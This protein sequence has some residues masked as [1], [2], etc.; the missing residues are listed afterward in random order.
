MTMTKKFPGF[1]KQMPAF[2]RGL[3]K[4]N[5]REWFAAHKEIFEAQARGPMME[6]AGRLNEAMKKISAEHVSAEPGRLLYRIYRD[7]RFSKDKTPYK[8]HL[9]ATFPHRILTR[10]G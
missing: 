4:N 1:S 6:L 10:H 5:E 9:G 3:E 2:F 8:T 7:T